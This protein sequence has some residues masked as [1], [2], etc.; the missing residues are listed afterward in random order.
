MAQSLTLG[1]V[2]LAF[3]APM[4]GQHQ[5]SAGKSMRAIRQSLLAL[6][7]ITGCV[8]AMAQQPTSQVR[9]FVREDLASEAIRLEESLKKEAARLPARA[10]PDL[11]REAGQ[12]MQ[13]NN[14][15][16]AMRSLG[17]ARLRHSFGQA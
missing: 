5:I 3:K 15:R 9:E 8:P 12:F 1:I 11:L 6:A 16:A 4:L 7:L 17:Q 2:W 13:R 10:V 14:P